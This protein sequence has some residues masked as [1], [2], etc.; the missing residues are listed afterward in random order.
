MAH[1]WYPKELINYL[2]SVTILVSVVMFVAFFVRGAVYVFSGL[3]R[4][5]GWY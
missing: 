5:M 4:V 3:T 2:C 1:D